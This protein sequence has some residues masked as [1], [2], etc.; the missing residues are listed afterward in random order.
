[1][2]PAIPRPILLLAIALAAILAY[3]PELRI[4]LIADDFPN[5]TQSLTWGAPEGFSTL[6]RDPQFRF[7]AT[8]YWSMFGFWQVGELTPWVYHVA[9][10]LLHILNV[11][12][13]FAVAS[14]L[15]TNPRRRA[16]GRLLR[17]PRRPPGGGEVVQRRW[18]TCP[19]ARR[20]FA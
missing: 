14:T 11:W 8:S 17:D 18:R 1:L 10:L 5:I 20:C 3:A 12:L 9:S 6:L 7:R 4:P 2:R 19:A 16:V 15:G 13:V